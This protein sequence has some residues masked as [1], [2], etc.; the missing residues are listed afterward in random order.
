MAGRP[1]QVVA[2][3][4]RAQAAVAIALDHALHHCSLGQVR[5]DQWQ[6]VFQGDVDAITGRRAQYQR[7]D[8]YARLELAGDRVEVALAHIQDRCR[9]MQWPALPADGEG[10][11]VFRVG[12]GDL[13]NAHR[14]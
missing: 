11:T 1:H 10:L 13:R 5:H 2:E 14:P 3:G 9:V 7:F 4:G 6:T 12:Y 8:R